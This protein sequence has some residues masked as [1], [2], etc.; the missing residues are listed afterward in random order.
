M[1]AM[2]CIKWV[3]IFAVSMMIFSSCVSSRISPSMSVGVPLKK[4]RPQMSDS[5]GMRLEGLIK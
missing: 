4:G 2:V 5:N 3:F 1:K